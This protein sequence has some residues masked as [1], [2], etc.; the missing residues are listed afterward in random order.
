MAI[1]ESGEDYLETILILHNETGFVRSIDIANRLGYSKPSISRAMTIL[2][3]SGYINVLKSGEIVFTDEGRKKAEE[4]YERHLVLRAFLTD[5]LK[6]SPETANNDA[7]RIEH[8]ISE[9]SFSKLKKFIADNSH[10]NID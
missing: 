10:K 9:E 3:E 8:V 1:Y 7:C 2:R 6:V 5:I 4:V